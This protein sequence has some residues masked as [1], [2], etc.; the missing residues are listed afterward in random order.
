MI[1]S[2]ESLSS[3]F[4]FVLIVQ[5]FDNV[6]LTVLDQDALLLLLDFTAQLLELLLALVR[7]FRHVFVAFV[8]ARAELLVNAEA[9][10]PG[11]VN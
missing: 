4:V 7:D 11:N 3:L 8:V 2:L 9:E 6:L 1:N 5:V 10:Y